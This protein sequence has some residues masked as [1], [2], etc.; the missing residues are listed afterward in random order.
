M[1]KQF[2][3]G[4]FI[5]AMLMLPGAVVVTTVV[6]AQSRVLRLFPTAWPWVPLTTTTLELTAVAVLV[7]A[8][9]RREWPE[10]RWRD[11]GQALAESLAVIGVAMIAPYWFGQITIASQ[12]SLLTCLNA[13]LFAVP[14]A[15]WCMAEEVVLRVVLP[16]ILAPLPMWSRY[17]SLL[18]L[19]CLVQWSIMTPQSYYIIAVIVAGECVSL[20]S[21]SVQSHFGLVWGRRWAWRWVT[22]GLLGAQNIGFATTLQSPAM[23]I[24]R[25]AATMMIIIGSALAIWIIQIGYAYLANRQQHDDD[26]NPE[27]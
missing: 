20:L 25:D 27:A 9:Y 16:R 23:P 24:V 12:V 7:W 17:S 18:V 2:G 22:V 4:Q 21:M 14:L 8:I 6:L 15:A 26:H 10:W 1:S 5:A 11:I 19:A 3:L 13:V